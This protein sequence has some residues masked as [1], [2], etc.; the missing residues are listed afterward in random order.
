MIDDP[1]KALGS[2][3]GDDLFFTQL[4]EAVGTP[5]FSL[6]IMAPYFIPTDVGVEALTELAR[7]GVE[8]QV[9]TNSL[10]ATDETVVH[11]GYAKWRDELLEHGV[12]L[13]ELKRGDDTSPPEKNTVGPYGSASATLHAKTFAV[14]GETLVVGSF[15]ADPRSVNLNTELGLV[16]HCPDLAKKVHNAFPHRVME[17]AYQV[18]LDDDGELYWLEQEGDELIRHQQEPGVGFLQRLFL[19]VL[20]VMPI[21]GFL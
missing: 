20:S 3:D 5:R 12:R 4:R 13:Y 14:D 17:Y 6:D 2:A 15:N 9:L 16:M 19:P 7:S 11:A 18:R 1:N 10:Q 8:I 21:E